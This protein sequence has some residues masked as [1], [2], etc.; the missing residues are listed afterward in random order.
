MIPFLV[1]AIIVVSPYMEDSYEIEDIRIV[2]ATDIQEA[3]SK[4]CSY[5]ESKDSEYGIHYY[6]DAK[7]ME[8]II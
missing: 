7:V 1:K 5:W 3:H 6:V 4:Y 8:T 2:I